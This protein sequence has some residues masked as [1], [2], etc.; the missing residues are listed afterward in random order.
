VLGKF[1]RKKRI[2]SNSVAWIWQT[3]VPI[4]HGLGV[5]R[6]LK[7]KITIKMCVPSTSLEDMDPILVPQKL[8]IA[9]F[10]IP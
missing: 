7:K 9:K 2:D 5:E 3:Q 1:N 10:S 4:L 8:S 6:T